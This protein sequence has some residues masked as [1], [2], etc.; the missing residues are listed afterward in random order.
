MRKLFRSGKHCST[1]RYYD[2]EQLDKIMYMHGFTS[3]D[4]IYWGYYPAGIGNVTFYLLDWLG[5]I[6]DKTRIRQYAGGLTVSYVL[7]SEGIY[8]CT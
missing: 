8:G 4:C 6:L 3:Q 2:K 7:K 5:K 1:D